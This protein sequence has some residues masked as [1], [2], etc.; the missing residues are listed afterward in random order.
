VNSECSVESPILCLV[1]IRLISHLLG[2]TV[3]D[4]LS[5]S[6]LEG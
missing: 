6:L 4:S 1:F 2:G 3:L 5:D